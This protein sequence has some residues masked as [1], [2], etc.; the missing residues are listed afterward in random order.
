MKRILHLL[1]ITL[2]LVQPASAHP[3]PFSFL[4][5]QLTPNGIEASLILH[6]F[7]LAHDLGITPT[8]RLHD[9]AFLSERA[10][11]I[12]AL[13]ASRLQIEADG[14]ELR[15]EWDMPEVLADRQAIRFTLHF[16]GVSRP[17]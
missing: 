8:E 17:G 13:L 1:L 14:R 12:H 11:S 6:D 4:D 9:P 10:A 5:L 7:D 16:P 3:V 15:P 2:V